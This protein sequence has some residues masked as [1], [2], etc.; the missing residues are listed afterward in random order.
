MK[1]TKRQL[2]RI[3]REEK[4]NLN[5]K[6]H[7]DTLDDELSN[8][9]KNI[10]NDLDHIKDLKKDVE[11]NKEEEHRDELDKARK[12]ESLRRFIKREVKLARR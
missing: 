1:I 9:K 6:L 10:N 8:L 2:L 3:I 12:D 11:D 7:E 5:R 4:I